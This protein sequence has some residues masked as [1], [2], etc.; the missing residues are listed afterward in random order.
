[1]LWIQASL[2]VFEQYLSWRYGPVMAAGLFV[3][4]AGAKA[5]SANVF[6]AGGVLVLLVL[7]AR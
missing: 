5:R 7:L 4:M 1:M 2:A 6:C 3:M